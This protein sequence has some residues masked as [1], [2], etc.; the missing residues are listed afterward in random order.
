MYYLFILFFIFYG[1][2]DIFVIFK[3]L[4]TVS[5][6]LKTSEEKHNNIYIYGIF[7][8]SLIK[9]ITLQIKHTYKQKF[10]LNNAI[11]NL[12]KTHEIL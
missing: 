4:V 3:L 7:N 6:F 5:G 11:F 1:N 12:K 2:K 8:K 9:F 10:F